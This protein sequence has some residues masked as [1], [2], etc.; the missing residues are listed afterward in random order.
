MSGQAAEIMALLARV[1]PPDL[2]AALAGGTA[3]ASM[4]A[5]AAQPTEGLLWLAQLLTFIWALIADGA[6]W[7]ITGLRNH[8]IEFITDI[9]ADGDLGLL[10]LFALADGGWTVTTTIVLIFFRCLHYSWPALRWPGSG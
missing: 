8:L 6:I 5:V 9:D 3:V 4:S 10:R 7:L 1:L 2:I